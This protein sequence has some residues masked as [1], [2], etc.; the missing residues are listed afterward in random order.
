MRVK[1]ARRG[2]LG[3]A[4]LAV[5]VLDRRKKPLMPC[6]PKRAQL[7]LERGRAVVRTRYPFT[8][9]LKDRVGG[10]TQP[11]RLRFDPGSKTTAIAVVRDEG[12]KRTPAV[13]SLIDLTHRGRR[14]SKHL[15]ARRAFRRRRRGANLRYRAPR[16]NHRGGDRAGWL[17]PSLRHRIDTCM[18]R[19]KRLRRWVP[20]TG[21]AAERVRFDMQLLENPEISGVAYQW[22]TPAGHEA[23]EYVLGRGGHRCAYCGVVNAPLNLDPVIPRANGGSNR[24]SNLVPACVPGNEA[25]GATPVEV[26]LADRQDVLAR[27]KKQIKAPL[28]D[29]AAVKA[30]RRAVYESLAATGLPAE[31][32]SGGRSK[33]NRSRFGIPK[34]H[35]LD[36]V[37]VREMESPTGWRKLDDRA[38]ATGR[39]TS[40]RTKLKANGCPRGSCK[41]NK[42]V[43]GFQ[44]GGMKR[45]DVPKGEKA[46]IHVGRLAIRAHGPFNLG[47]VTDINW[48]HVRLLQRSD[49][50][51]YAVSATPVNPLNVSNPRPK[52]RVPIW[53][54]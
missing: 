41:R 13:L 17:P 37:C 14:I 54:L 2:I 8:I 52:G 48:K 21:I 50:F 31:V 51:G 19:V 47:S 7:L 36:A 26:F 35:A 18:S 30:T 49:G 46:V 22:G 20:V 33:F 27:I 38:K 32:S 24:P 10:E 25:K 44:T 42:R 29:A 39:G 3:V 5:F 45:A 34:G 12:T 6:P 4:K 1:W 53:S 43:H 9:R 23:R 40:C 11:V 28:N 16:F 15:N